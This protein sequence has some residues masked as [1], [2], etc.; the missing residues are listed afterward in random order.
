VAPPP[1]DPNALIADTAD[2]ATLPLAPIAAG[3]TR[4]EAL[5]SADN[6]RP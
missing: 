3:M 4:L 1:G 2:I 6:M 5:F